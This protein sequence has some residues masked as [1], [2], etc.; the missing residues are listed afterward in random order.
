ML[1]KEFLYNLTKHH[2]EFV[3][4]VVFGVSSIPGRALGWWVL[5][6]EGVMLTRL[7]VEAFVWKPTAPALPT[8]LLELWNAFSYDVHVV[9]FDF[10]EAMR[11]RVF[12]RDGTEAAGEYLFTVD[13]Y[14][15]SD[16]EDVGDLGHKCGHVIALDNGCFAVQPN[17]RIFWQEPSFVTRPLQ[18]RP[19]YLTL[20]RL[21][22]C[23]QHGKW[24]TGQEDR[25]FFEAEK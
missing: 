16:S 3:R 22:R 12:L 24:T 7:P 21:F 18:A 15:S 5:T 20:N 8:H 14:G 2:G 19:D 25:M 17:N 13:W 4:C 10:L 6:E 1:R 9:E 23:E 11:C